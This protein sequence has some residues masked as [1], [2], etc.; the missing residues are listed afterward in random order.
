MALLLSSCGGKPG[1]ADPADTLSTRA[2]QEA[3]G[4]SGIPG[5][6]GINR[7]LEVADSATARQAALDSLIRSR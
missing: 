1:A 7:A 3:I 2:R 5:A 4:R 6:T